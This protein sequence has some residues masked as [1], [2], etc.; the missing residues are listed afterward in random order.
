MKIILTALLCMMMCVPVFADQQTTV[1]SA[2]ASFSKTDG[3]LPYIDGSND[4]TLE[5][6]ANNILQ[7]KAKKLLQDVGG[8]G[9]ISY[10]V[11]LNR[12]SLVGVLLKAE[13]NGC[14]A[15]QGV[16]I[17]L[18]SGRE[19]TAGDFYTESDEFK[20]LVKG[21]SDLLFAEKGIYLRAGGQGNYD[22]F[23]GYGKLMP[24]MRIGDAGRLLQIAR[25]TQNAADK[26]LTVPS[27]SL[28]ALKLDSNPS[29]G[30]RWEVKLDKAAEGRIQ[31]VG[32]S[33]IMPHSNDDRVGTPGTEILVL[34]AQE[35]GECLVT[36]EYKRPWE[37]QAVNSFSFKVVIKE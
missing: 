20:A 35:P 1:L 27:G 8:Q 16:N 24:Y 22:T 29:S 3:M 23:I 4:V 11:K 33:F 36:L 6:Q 5:K 13:N 19:F 37:K 2:P 18:T 10:E 32:S 21:G 28:M 15:Y 30:Y 14:V 26:V 9:H 31:K 25:L 34:T 12:P 7:E 17:D